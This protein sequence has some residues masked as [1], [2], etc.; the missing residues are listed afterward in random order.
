[1]T[2]YL[3]AFLI[4][5]AVIVVC[6]FLLGLRFWVARRVAKGSVPAR[7]RPPRAEPVD[8]AAERRAFE[9]RRDAFLEARDLGRVA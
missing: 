2:G 6:L 1:M 8:L 4:T 3:A 9:S 7:V 5:V